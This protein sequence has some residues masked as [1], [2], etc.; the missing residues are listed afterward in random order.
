MATWGAVPLNE[1]IATR[2][3]TEGVSLGNP[4]GVVRTTNGADRTLAAGR[5]AYVPGY[6][7]IENT[8][9]LEIGDGA[10][11]EIG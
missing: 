4:P 7:E 6:Y 3:A 5:G 10:E 1:E 9:N 11:L 8:R 2:M